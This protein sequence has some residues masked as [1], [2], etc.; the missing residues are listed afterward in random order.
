[1]SGKCYLQKGLLYT[2]WLVHRPQCVG[3]NFDPLL[4]P[5]PR[6]FYPDRYLNTKTNDLTADECVNVLDPRQRDHR[7]FRAE[8]RVC[9]GYELAEKSLFV[10]TARLLWAFDVKA[11]IQA[12]GKPLEYVLWDFPAT[13]SSPKRRYRAC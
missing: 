1:M 8:R 2:S 11:S 9:A 7:G 12:N 10:L 4:F 6:R 3:L 5:D 13:V